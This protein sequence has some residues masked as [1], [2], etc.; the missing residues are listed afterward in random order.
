[1][2][3]PADHL[4]TALPLPSDL[5]VKVEGLGKM[6]HLYDRQMDRLKQILMGRLGRSYGRPFWAL[7]DISFEIKK[8]ETFGIIGKNG[9]GKSTLLQIMAGILQPTTGQVKVNGRVAALLELG[10]GFNPE[11]SG[12]E[13][14]ILNGMILGFSRLEMEEKFPAIAEFADIGD[15]INQPVKVYSSG[16]FV[17]LAFA[18]AAGIDADLVL[19]DEALAVGDI[20]FRQKCYRRLQELREKGT[21]IVLVSH[22]MNEVEEFCE[23]A[24]LLNDSRLLYLGPAVETVKRYYFVQ[25]T[26]SMLPSLVEPKI[27]DEPRESPSPGGLFDWP[28]PEAF[29]DTTKIEQVSDQRARCT[30]VAV[31]DADGNPC[32]VFQQGQT[33]SFFFEFIAHEEIEVPIGGV[34]ILNEKGIIVHGKNSLLY[35]SP[36]PGYV[37]KGSRV[38]F[39]QDIRLDLAAGEYTFNVGFSTISQGDYERKNRLPHPELDARIY[40]LGILPKA[41]KFVIVYRLDGEPVQLLH[42]GVANLPGDC[43]VEVY[44]PDSS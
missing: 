40:V 32:L 19:V 35:G 13:N 10:S 41:G 36:A 7:R 34:E 38:R 20:F 2:L 29:L 12:R 22:A 8:G 42:F 37:S 21:S 43:Q 9:S 18:V 6:Y 17:R 27:H 39:R 33:A 1:M 11:F 24:M 28:P 3:K 25:Q 44:R 14:V 15:F 30:G 26:G 16:M 23:R 31:C 5:I 4:Q